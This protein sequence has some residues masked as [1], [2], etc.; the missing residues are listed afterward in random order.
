M[1]AQRGVVTTEVG[2]SRESKGGA[3]HQQAQWS[4]LLFEIGISPGF[5]G[6][7]GRT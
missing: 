1:E 2:K 3:V 4:R 7:V 5:H 6:I